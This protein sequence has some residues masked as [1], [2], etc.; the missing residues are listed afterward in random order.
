[1]SQVGASSPKS[2]APSRRQHVHADDQVSEVHCF[3][4]ISSALCCASETC[5]SLNAFA[6]EIQGGSRFWSLYHRASSVT[7]NGLAVC[8]GSSVTFFIVACLIAGWAISAAWVSGKQ[9]WQ[10]SMQVSACSSKT[11]PVLM[12]V[13]TAV[14]HPMMRHCCCSHTSFQVAAAAPVAC[15]VL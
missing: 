12:F 6:A 4:C 9:I 11:T 2:M 3:D 14:A 13:T 5:L 10:I 7:L 15:M 8:A 1:M